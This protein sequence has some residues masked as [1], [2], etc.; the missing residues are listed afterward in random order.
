VAQLC[1]RVFFFTFRSSMNSVLYDF[2]GRLARHQKLF[3][4]RVLLGTV[5]L[6]PSDMGEKGYKKE[7]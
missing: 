7:Q 2:V 6:E 5:L 4:S 1:V 3:V